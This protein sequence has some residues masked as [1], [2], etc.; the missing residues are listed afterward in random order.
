MG[1]METLGRI[2]KI[3][4]ANLNAMLDK[5]E[6]PARMIDQ[7]L[8]DAKRD[9]AD[10][11]RDTQEAMAR[12]EMSKKKLAEC[13]ED[14]AKK[15][16]AATNALKAGNEGDARTLLAAKQSLERTRTTLAQNV[17]TAEENVD[18]LRDGY[19]KLVANIS[20]LENQRDAA[21]DK[22]AMAK[23]QNKINETAA[24]ASSTTA[25]D[26]MEKYTS[27]ADRM[28]AE[29]KAGAELDKGTGTADDLTEK[30]AGAGCDASVEDE[31]ARMKA[32]LGMS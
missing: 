17:A 13:D 23:T 24:K 22:I 11:K 2:P 9:L 7:L 31:L 16:L 20:Y 29:A 3:M 21:K 10:V 25:L 6:D 19:N 30:Y 1:L 5:C 15:Q 28:L 12:L 18:T 14:I 8:V 4:E 26:A 27:Q 32:E